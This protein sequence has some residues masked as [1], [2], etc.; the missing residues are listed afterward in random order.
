M[1]ELKDLN[2]SKN[3]SELGS[4]EVIRHAELVSASQSKEVSKEVSKRL[5]NFSLAIK[6]ACHCEDERSEDVA[7]AKSLNINEITTQSSIARNDKSSSETLAEGATHVDT[8]DGKRKIAFTLAEVLITLG[9]IGVVASLTLPS[10]VAHYKEK[11]LVTQ[12]QK[13]YSEMQNALKMYSAQNNCSDIT[14]ISDTNQTSAQLADKLFAQFQGAKKCPGNYDYSRKICKAVQIKNK[15]PY[16]Q[17]GVASNPDALAPYF[18]S[19][20][21][22]AYKVLQYNKCPS[23]YEVILRDEAGFP[24]LDEDGK[25]KKNK[26]KYVNCALIYFDANG[27]NKGP[28]Q[29]GADIYR[30]DLTYDGKFISYKDMINPALTKGKLEYTPYKLGEPKK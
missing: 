11:V 6:K 8:C 10:V 19:A 30:F 22:V 7:I 14:C 26:G 25:P 5:R 24:I 2:K 12:V 4:K 23:E 17:D 1:E 27:V 13:A 9:I 21:G 20:N 29:Y 28:N 15:T 16:Y 18:I 3:V